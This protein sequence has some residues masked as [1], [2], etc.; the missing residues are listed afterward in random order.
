MTLEQRLKAKSLKLKYNKYLT[1]SNYKSKLCNGHKGYYFIKSRNIKIQELHN[2]LLKEKSYYNSFYKEK[3][4][5]PRILKS[6][7]WQPINEDYYELIAIITEYFNCVAIWDNHFYGDQ[8]EPIKTIRV[9]GF[10]P[11]IHICIRYLSNEINNLQSLQ[12]NRVQYYR[13]IRRRVRRNG[14][15]TSKMKDARTKGINYNRRMLRQ[16]SDIWL[17]ILKETP[18]RKYRE[19]KYEAIFD[20]LEKR[21]ML[22][23]NK[24]GKTYRHAIC[25]STKFIHGR[26]ISLKKV[27]PALN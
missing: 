22:N 13:V 12:F 5:L 26:I 20:I 6:R 3:G 15:D 23:Y 8:L 24:Q 10:Q 21:G 19:D 2:L 11:D 4:I 18:E 16:L 14:R 7:M 17:N 27:Y 25:P 1:F 9:F